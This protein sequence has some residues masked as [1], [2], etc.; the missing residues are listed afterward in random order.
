VDKRKFTEF[1]KSTVSPS[2]MPGEP[3]IVN[4]YDMVRFIADKII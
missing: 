3:V 1:T 4:I 2:S